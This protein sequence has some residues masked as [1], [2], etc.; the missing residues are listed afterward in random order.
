MLVRESAPLAQRMSSKTSTARIKDA[1][2]EAKCCGRTLA[3]SRTGSVATP[4]R[5]TAGKILFAMICCIFE[6]FASMF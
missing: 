6:K 3:A 1:S 2:M 5:F 4:Y